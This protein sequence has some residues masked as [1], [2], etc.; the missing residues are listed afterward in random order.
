MHQQWINCANFCNWQ[1]LPLRIQRVRVRHLSFVICEQYWYLEKN[2]CQGI[3]L[4]IQERQNGSVNL[5]TTSSLLAP[6]IFPKI[7]LRKRLVPAW[8]VEP[9][10]VGWVQYGT[11]WYCEASLVE[12][13]KRNHESKNWSD[14]LRCPSKHSTDIMLHFLNIKCEKKNWLEC[15]KFTGGKALRDFSFAI[16]FCFHLNFFLLY[17]FR[18]QIYFL[19]RFVVWT[20]R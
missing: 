14:C 20:S 16:W 8:L 13:T 2:G 7:K 15:Y 17:I 4:R 19:F 3:S 9:S 18:Q 6:E 11:G 5:K 10:L 12:R 1:R